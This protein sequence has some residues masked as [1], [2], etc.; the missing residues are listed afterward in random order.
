M[1]IKKFT[2]ELREIIDGSQIHSQYTTHGREEYKN[3]PIAP[4]DEAIVVNGPEGDDET[5]ILHI[6]KVKYDKP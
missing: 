2:K 1:N 3:M 6:I 5:F 4:D